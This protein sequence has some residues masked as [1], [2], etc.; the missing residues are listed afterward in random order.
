[1]V[2]LFISVNCTRLS[3]KWNRKV[4]SNEDSLLMMKFHSVDLQ[5]NIKEG[6][7]TILL[8]VDIEYLYFHGFQI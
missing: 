8:Y 4:I 3:K 1:M 2:V 7:I 5:A 6:K